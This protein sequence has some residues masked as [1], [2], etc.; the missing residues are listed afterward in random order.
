[1]RD[2]GHRGLI[3]GEP[4]G[5]AAFLW[6]GSH[7]KLVEV[8]A[9]RRIARS[10]TTLAGELTLALALHTVLAASLPDDLFE[11]LDPEAL[12]AGARLV[13]REGLG[14]SAFLVRVAGLTGT[15]SPRERASFWLGAAIA[16]DVAHLAR[17]AILR[18][19]CPVWVGGRQPQRL[20]VRRLAR[21][22]SP[23]AGD[24]PGR[25]T[26]RGGLGPGGAGGR[27]PAPGTGFDRGGRY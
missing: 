15:F 16:D 21:R 7:T 5:T 2:A 8:D 14:R 10:H 22:P 18:G 4:S 24:R 1:M 25:R 12:E 13:A 9:G 6:P 19:G 20:P 27:A 3:R 17:H 26:G 11:D 23:G